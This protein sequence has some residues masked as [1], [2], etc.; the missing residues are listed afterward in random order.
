MIL[1]H[2]MHVYLLLI[3]SIPIMCHDISKK[4]FF[5][6]VKKNGIFKEIVHYSCSKKIVDKGSFIFNQQKVVY[7]HHQNFSLLQLKNQI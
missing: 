3:M 2:N 6:M 1:L 5:N 7:K 4:K